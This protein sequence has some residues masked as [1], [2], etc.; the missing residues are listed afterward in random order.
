[1]VVLPFSFLNFTWTNRIAFSIPPCLAHARWSVPVSISRSFFIEDLLDIHMASFWVGAGLSKEVT[2][3]HG[4]SLF[5]M[6]SAQLLHPVS[7]R[8]RSSTLTHRSSLSL[9]TSQ[10]RRCCFSSPALYRL[11]TSMV[12]RKDKGFQNQTRKL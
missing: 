3:A 6:T 5:L 12:S 10:A 7:G 1:M 4:G 11:E 2:Q 9:N 8:S